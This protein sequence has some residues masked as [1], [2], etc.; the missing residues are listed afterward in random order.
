MSSVVAPASLPI[1]LVQQQRPGQ[2]LVHNPSCLLLSFHATALCLLFDM[3]AASVACCQ[4]Q[5]PLFRANLVRYP[6]L[7]GD[8]L[9]CGHR[10]ERPTSSAP[11]CWL[12]MAFSIA[13]ANRGWPRPQLL[14]IGATHVLDLRYCRPTVDH[15]RPLLR[16]T[17]ISHPST[18]LSSDCHAL[19]SLQMAASGRYCSYRANVAIASSP[20]RPHAPGGGGVAV[21]QRPPPSS[22]IAPPTSP[23]VDAAKQ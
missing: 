3:S 23:P 4:Q 9:I 16:P 7:T 6:P 14:L 1:E 12:G 19:S 22:T 2:Y 18:L 11:F 8:S 10:S 20:Q 17:T 21:P 13:A 5:R 15:H